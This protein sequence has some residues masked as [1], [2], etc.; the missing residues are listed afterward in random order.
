M[1]STPMVLGILN[2]HLFGL[3]IGDI[4]TQLGIIRCHVALSIFLISTRVFL[5][6]GLL[7]ESELM[8][9]ATTALML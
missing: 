7:L 4:K 9:R 3:V 8:Q 1:S 2:Q 5:D 6:I